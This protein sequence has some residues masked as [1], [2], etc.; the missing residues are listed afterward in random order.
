M[1]DYELN[2]HNIF[3]STPSSQKVTAATDTFAKMAEFQSTP[4]SQKVTTIKRVE[5]ICY[6][7]SIHTFLAEGDGS[8]GS[9]VCQQGISIH[10]FL[11]EGDKSGQH[12]SLNCKISIHT[13]L[14]EGDMVVDYVIATVS[15]FNPHLPR[16]R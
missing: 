6:T 7:I 16:R 8:L 2:Y 15:D 14:A 4:S 13:F 11:A 3:Q 1:S 9:N 5:I 10:T 12:G